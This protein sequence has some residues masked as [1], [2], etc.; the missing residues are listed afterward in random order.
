MFGSSLFEIEKTASHEDRFKESS[1]ILSKYTDRLPIIC[2]KSRYTKDS[3]KL[4]KTK[5]LVPES[6]TVA[7]FM[8]VIRHKLPMLKEQAIFLFLKNGTTPA[9]TATIKEVYHQHES[10]DGFL[11]ISYSLENTFG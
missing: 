1:N 9:N 2:E 10:S 8:Y 6:L 7:H 4:D 3:L 5:Y 11:Y